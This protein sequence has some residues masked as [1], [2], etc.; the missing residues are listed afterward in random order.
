MD[1]K[2]SSKA[3]VIMEGSL[4]QRVIEVTE[5]RAITCYGFQ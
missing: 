3:N 4:Q 1:A 2:T 5:Q